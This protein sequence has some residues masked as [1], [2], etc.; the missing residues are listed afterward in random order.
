MGNSVV[1]I[2]LFR[3]LPFREFIKILYRGYL[4]AHIPV[5]AGLVGGLYG[6]VKGSVFFGESMFSLADNASKVAFA[7]LARA[8]FASG[9][10][11]IDSQV[12]TEN[13]AA[14]GAVEITRLAYLRELA[15]HVGVSVE[16]VWPVSAP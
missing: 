9:Y 11:L 6:V 10:A 12:Y 4:R 14:F 15:Q 8:L 3:E 2:V 13:L 16:S 1:Y 7:T 5:M